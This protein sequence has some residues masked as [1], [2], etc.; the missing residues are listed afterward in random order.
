MR[1][2]DKEKASNWLNSHSSDVNAAGLSTKRIANII[3][4]FDNPPIPGA[5][6][7]C[8]TLFN[9]NMETQYPDTIQTD[10]QK[11][12]MVFYV[13]DTYNTELNAFIKSNFNELA[14]YYSEKDI[15]FC[16]VPFLLQDKDYKTVVNY[17]R[18]YLQT[19]IDEKTISEIYQGIKSQLREP[20]EGGGLV[21]LDTEGTSNYPLSGKLSEQ[22]EQLLQEIEKFADEISNERLRKSNDLVLKSRYRADDNVCYSYDEESLVDEVA[23]TRR[24]FDSGISFQIISDADDN[25]EYDAF[26]LADE[27]RSRI[28][29]LQETGSLFLIGDILEEIQGVSTKLSSIFITNDYRIFLKDYGMKEVV[30]PPLAKSLYI[31]F[32][33]H[34][35]G[36]LFKKLIDYH[37]ELLSIYRT[38]YVHE[39][40]DRAKRS[41]RAMTNPMD[42]SINE[43][44]SHIRAAF[45]GVI[46]DNLAE[47]YYVTGKRGEAKK[48]I[49]DRSMVEFQ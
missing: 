38:I 47:N 44:C 26:R 18:P 11:S 8:I 12:S 25:F 4:N 45:L 32:L 40:I 29:L 19:G 2:V 5:T 24:E 43:K 31:L 7:T 16:Y 15:D 48:I 39:N 42:N 6:I 41:I 30:M 9:Y 28:R 33:R 22:A 3:R 46:A 36:I 20:L 37:D 27:I 17:N 23:E 35:K 14:G 13:E 49:L 1:W 34:P 21:K 10:P